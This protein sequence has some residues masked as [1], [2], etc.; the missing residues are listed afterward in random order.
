MKIG[1]RTSPTFT[2]MEND[3]SNAKIDYFLF[4][5]V[6][7]TVCPDFWT[8]GLHKRNA[9]PDADVPLFFKFLPAREQD[10]DAAA[11]FF[12]DLRTAPMV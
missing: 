4:F 2:I 8:T 10:G 11:F 12:L 6:R 1:E 9:L 3:L 5:L 7:F